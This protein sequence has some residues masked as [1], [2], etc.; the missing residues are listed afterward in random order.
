M[1]SNSPVYD[2]LYEPLKYTP[3]APVAE[4]T[5]ILEPAPKVTVEFLTTL[6]TALP[7]APVFKSWARIPI[8]PAVVPVDNISP[9]WTISTN[10]LPVV[11]CVALVSDTPK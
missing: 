6:I 5:S 10:P 7:F 1:L 4:E 11:G 2:G 8:A 9:L 3:L